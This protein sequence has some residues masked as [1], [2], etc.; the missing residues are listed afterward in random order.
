M[1]CGEAR[2]KRLAK[3]L[4]HS[5]F[6]QT[7]AKMLVRRAPAGRINKFLISGYT[8]LGHFVLK[9][10]LIRKIEELY[11]GCRVYIIAGNS[12]GSEHV[13]HS[14]P[15]MILKQDSGALTKL[16]FFLKL[17]KEKF[18]AVF[19]PFDASP[20]FLI[21]GSIAA[22]IPIRVG[23]VFDH[24]PMPSYYYTIKVPVIRREVRSEIDMNLD[25]LQ[26]LYG[27]PFQ[28]DYRPF[29]EMDG[30]IGI[31]EA[32]GLQKNTYI[33]LQM[34]ASNGLPS[35]KRWLEGN[36][37]ELI[38]KLLDSYPHLGI[39]ALGDKGD[40][41]IVNRICDGIESERL[42]NLSGK[43]SL[44]ETKKLIS[45]CRFLICHD[46]GLLHLGNALQKQVIAI[47]GPSNPDFYALSL[48][49]CHVLRKPCDC[50]PLLGLFPGMLSE[51]TEAE[52]AL[53]CPV[54]RCMER[55]TVDEVYTKC[56]ELLQ[57]GR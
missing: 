45:D 25:L 48:S 18:D 7:L 36:F 42:K 53:K 31:L 5:I 44:D 16:I 19:F 40:S 23:H 11:P 29:V 15:I 8:G 27:K 46:S 30:E 14:Y 4:G 35:P 26:A 12:F 39:V 21:R 2:M 24:I 3:K 17:R 32:N 10:V 43:I 33:C 37:R 50:T 13:L 49:T 38:V 20:K 28:R 55:L 54:P 22:G 56:A 1:Y 52:V 9:T 47:Y 57:E 34:G 6:G 41:P 51:P